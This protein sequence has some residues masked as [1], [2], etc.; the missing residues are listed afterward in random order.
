MNVMMIGHQGKE[1]GVARALRVG[2]HRF[3]QSPDEADC[4]FVDHD[5]PGFGPRRALLELFHAQGKAT[6]I[7]PHGAGVMLS[8]DGPVDPFPVTA[9]FVIGEGQA[10]VMRRYGYPSP[11][12]VVGWSLCLQRPF[13]PLDRVERVLFAPI[14]PPSNPDFPPF[15]EHTAAN[16]AAFKACRSLG[17]ELTVRHIGDPRVNGLPVIDGVRYVEGG[18]DNSIREIDEADLVVS[19]DTFASLAVAR[20]K[21][22]V[23]FGQDGNARGEDDERAPVKH[24]EAY[25]DYM[26]YPF[27]IE[28]GPM[29]EIVAAAAV[30]SDAADEWRSL[31]VGE[32][33]RPAVFCRTVE[34]LAG[35]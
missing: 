28:D 25:A 13:V 8:W 10:E 31:F 34:E 26:R 23:Q 14:H 2:G 1:D 29:S 7:Y 33:L 20:G 27:D 35:V 12:V 15:P 9:Q 24:W 4:L 22:V 11:L 21:P 32:P 17:V 6:F 30:G 3:V 19:N 18:Y 16:V 5:H